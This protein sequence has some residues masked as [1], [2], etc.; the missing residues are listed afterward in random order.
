MGFHIYGAVR[1]SEARNHDVKTTKPGAHIRLG[2]T[3]DKAH[4][5]AIPTDFGSFYSMS[6]KPR[7]FRI[8]KS[9]LEIEA[10]MVV[11]RLSLPRETKRNASIARG[12]DLDAFARFEV[13]HVFSNAFSH[14]KKLEPSFR[15]DTHER[16][17]MSL[18]LPFL[19]FSGIKLVPVRSVSVP[20]LTVLR[21]AR[22]A[23]P[24]LP[25]SLLA[26]RA[27]N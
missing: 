18:T 9:R 23:A 13:C 4:Q 7:G 21:R 6:K 2:Q 26:C 3:S 24:A 16:N 17:T 11:P 19:S 10:E 12:S 20:P 1:S 14:T 8:D 25:P 5:Q 15:R 22:S 27:G